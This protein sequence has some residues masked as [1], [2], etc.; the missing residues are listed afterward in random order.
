MVCYDFEA[1][2]PFE[3]PCL[4][5]WKLFLQTTGQSH[6]GVTFQKEQAD[7]LQG[8]PKQNHGEVVSAKSVV[9]HSVHVAHSLHALRQMSSFQASAAH[10]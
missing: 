3:S 8:F 7:P 6:E 10:L 5:V 1:S 9:G 2:F 4:N